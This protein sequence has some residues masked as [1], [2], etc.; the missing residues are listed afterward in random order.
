MTI[1]Q[2]LTEAVTRF[3]AE[4]IQSARL[5]AELLIGFVLG[6]DRTQMLLK[7]DEIIL[8]ADEKKISDLVYRRSQGEPVAYL[9]GER[10]FYKYSFKV[11]SD[12]LVPRPETEIIVE[13]AIKILRVKPENTIL[14]F[15]CGS[16]CIGLSILKEIPNLNLIAVDISPR[17]LDVAKENAHR[18]NVIDRCQFIECDVVDFSKNHPLYKEIGLILANPPY[19]DAN[20]PSL[21]KKSLSFE[22]AGALY[23]LDEGC[24]DPIKWAKVASEILSPNKNLL[25]EIGAGQYDRLE[26]ELDQWFQS[27]SLIKDLA[28]FD[29]VIMAV[30]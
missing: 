30:R 2:A 21:D 13:E 18:L 17:A 7:A 6:Y 9:T 19:I 5:D 22:P 28:G 23:S 11:N 4:N 12:V 24:L 29:R 3:K 26:K 1:K 14:D 15:G 20:D 16:G 8:E 10:E 27:V 25:M